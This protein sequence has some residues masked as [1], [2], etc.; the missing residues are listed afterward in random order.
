MW[1]QY[2]AAIN[3][4][5]FGLPCLMAGADNSLIHAI[6][7]KEN[8]GFHCCLKFANPTEHVGVAVSKAVPSALSQS[9][10]QLL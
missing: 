3:I 8:F 10:C 5:A 7:N 4:D 9:A 1:L 2:V 6:N